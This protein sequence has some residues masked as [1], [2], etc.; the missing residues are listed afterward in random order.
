MKKKLLFI[1]PLATLCVVG[2]GASAY[3][4]KAEDEPIIVPIVEEEPEEQEVEELS[5]EEVSKLQ[6]VLDKVNEEYAKLKKAYDKAMQTEF[7]GITLGTIIG[8]V[9]TLLMAFVGRSVDNKNLKNACMLV[10]KNENLQ[11]AS[12]ELHEKAQEKL[13]EYKGQLETA[14]KENTELRENLN[15][16]IQTVKDVIETNKALAKDLDDV[17]AIVL[18]MAYSNKDLVK[19]GV[20]SDLH[21]NYDKE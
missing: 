11:K 10:E 14:L 7:L 15:F 8:G 19:S 9:I 20:A 17:K 13:E 4:V 6:E 21:E 18:K 1:L 12:K 2:V 5:A 3:Q 16:A